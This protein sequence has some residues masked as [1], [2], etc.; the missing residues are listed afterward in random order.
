MVQPG[1]EQPI[2]SQ[3]QL[4]A[5]EVL[6]LGSGGGSQGSQQRSG[7]V[8]KTF[9]GEL[10]AIRRH[11]CCISVKLQADALLNLIGR[12]RPVFMQCVFAKTDSGSGCFDVPA[13]R[14]Q[15]HSA[16]ILPALQLY[17]TGYSEHVT[18]SDFRCRFQALSPL[19][20]KRCS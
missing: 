10:A 17:H 8:R 9:S 15:L 18:L 12:A 13:L 2:S 19:V 3:C 5:A 1:S 6:C 11:S 20:M 16:H 4:A 14:V 7:T